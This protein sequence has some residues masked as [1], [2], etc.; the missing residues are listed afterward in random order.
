[1]IA[2]LKIVNRDRVKSR[3]QKLSGRSVNDAEAG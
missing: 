1:M 2:K 3:V